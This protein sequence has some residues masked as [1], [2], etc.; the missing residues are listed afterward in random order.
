MPLERVPFLTLTRAHSS[1]VLD[2]DLSAPVVTER[3]VILE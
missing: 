3:R 1:L 2:A